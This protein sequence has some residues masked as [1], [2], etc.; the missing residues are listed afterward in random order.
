MRR[1]RIYRWIA[2]AVIVLVGLYFVV[3]VVTLQYMQSR[4][5]AET[6]RGMAAQ[7]AK[8]KLGSVPFLPGFLFGHTSNVSAT[9]DGATATGGFGVDQIQFSASSV[10]FSPSH[11]FSLARSLFSTQTKVTFMQPSCTVQLAESD[12]SQYIEHTVADVG[13]VQVKPTGIEIRFKLPL[14]P[15]TASPTATPSPSPTPTP[16]PQVQLTEPARFLPRIEN[17]RF[18]L[19]LIDVSQIGAQF[20]DDASQ[21][22][23][24]INLPPVPSSMNSDVRL[25]KGVIVI[26]SQGLSLTVTVGQGPS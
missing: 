24:L 9:I 7:G 12:L 16:S 19:T 10:H 5:G 18:V 6:A 22:E 2:V 11:M 3:D 15:P 23:N 21:I 14:L 26:E 8:V 13:Q 20:R 25:G 17:G 1:R 4:A